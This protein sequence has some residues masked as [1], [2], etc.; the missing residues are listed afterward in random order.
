MLNWKKQCSN[1]NGFNDLY[2]E[3]T[4]GNG[5]YILD[6]VQLPDTC[7]NTVCTIEF[8]YYDEH[9]VSIRCVEAPVNYTG[10]CP[11]IGLWLSSG[12]ADFDSLDDMKDFLLKFSTDYIDRQG[13][14]SPDD[15]TRG[16]STED[17]DETAP[18][19]MKYDKDALTIPKPY[20]GFVK[21]DKDK[22]LLD[23]TSEIFGQENVL[24]M[25]T[26]LVYIFLG[27]KGKDRPLSIFLYG[28]SGTGKTETAIQLVEMINRQLPKEAQRYI[29]R[30]IDCTHYIHEGDISRLTG[31]APGYIGHD[32]DGPFAVTEDNP[33][34]IYGINEIEKAHAEIAT[35]LMEAMDTGR[36][37][38]NGKTLSTG[39]AYYDLSNCILI[40]TSN[41][42]VDDKKKL[43]FTSSDV[44]L[45]MQ[46]EELENLNTALKIIQLSNAAKEKL[47]EAG[48]FRKEVLGRMD[49]VLKF[50]K[51]SGEAII[52]I[53]V[54]CIEKLAT[55]KSKLYITEIETPILQE[56]INVVAN[57]SS[58]SFGARNP[59]QYANSYFGDAFVRFS[60][61]HP[62][63][64]HIRVSG[65]LNNI[66]I[67][68]DNE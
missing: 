30:D 47:A 50:N 53:C 58:G 35:A 29:Y 42:S 60:W 56:F 4:S 8:R 38:T 15:E 46:Q 11:Q 3:M 37:A 52:Q 9:H 12:T 67:E 21:L 6:D 57:N 31:A 26:H 39:K 14:L 7:G 65:R 24:E 61:D 66:R 59:K 36:M 28:P 54:K 40:F 13:E 51:L 23:L 55:K 33:Y 20:R 16:S 22:L 63:Y 41:I 5:L 48:V 68:E 27:S 32:E 34:V 10:S 18:P 2:E 25:I 17:S 19:R 1:V 43:G 44:A 45:E 49:A 62:D 64:T